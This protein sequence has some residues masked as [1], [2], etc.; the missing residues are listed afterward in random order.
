M[1]SWHQRRPYGGAGGPAV[2]RGPHPPHLRGDGEARPRVGPT[3]QR[4]L[5]ESWPRGSRDG[6]VDTMARR[7]VKGVD[8][9]MERER[10][11]IVDRPR[12]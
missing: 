5:E 1:S 6:R 7:D 10:M 12:P 11:E 4:L 8:H 9:A 2:E 3:R